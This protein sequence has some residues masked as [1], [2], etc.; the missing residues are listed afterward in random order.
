MPERVKGWV[1]NEFATLV[2][3]SKRLLTR[4]LIVMTMLSDQPDKSTWLAAGSRGQAKAVYRMLA[5]ENLTDDAVISAH[6]DAIG[7]RFV[8]MNADRDQNG[9]ETVLLAVQDTMSVNYDGHR[10][11][12]G[13]GYTGNNTLGVSVHSCLLMDLSGVPLGVLCQSVTTRPEPKLPG[14]HSE[15]RKRPIED[16]ESYR[17]LETMSEAAENAP[18]G[19]KLIH[20][21]DRE[22]DIYELFS[23]AQSTGQLFVIRAVHDRLDSDNAHIIRTVDGSPLVGKVS[24]NIPENHAKKQKERVAELE[25]ILICF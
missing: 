23:L 6:R 18:K 24:V 25:L 21:A 19:V 3:G 13:L 4:F 7:V 17:W 20:V 8:E 1:R 22:G 5:N 16:K 2:T 12:E 14:T 11:T 15:Q 9:R 10:K